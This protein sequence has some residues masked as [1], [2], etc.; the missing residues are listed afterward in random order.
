MNFNKDSV[1]DVL[2]Q[3]F[4][5]P[6]LSRE[7]NLRNI[8]V[9][10]KLVRLVDVETPYAQVAQNVISKQAFRK[11]LQEIISREQQGQLIRG[12][13][14]TPAIGELRVQT[15]G[16]AAASSSG[17]SN[18]PSDYRSIKSLLKRAQK[19]RAKL[20]DDSYNEIIFYKTTKDKDK[21]TK[22]TKITEILIDAGVLVAG[23]NSSKLKNS[24]R[25]AGGVLQQ[26]TI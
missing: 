1:F 14:N 7:Q 5:D 25:S 12:R 4:G 3:Y 26:K 20:S 23:R 19:Q 11:V 13:L 24:Q 18:R 22:I 2:V 21:I 15:G 16:G 6:E 8:V 9:L 10:R 17:L